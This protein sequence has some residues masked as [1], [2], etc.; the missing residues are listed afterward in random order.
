M[1]KFG[2]NLKISSDFFSF[3]K[4][5]ELLNLIEKISKRIRVLFRDS[6]SLPVIFAIC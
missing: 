1:H 2:E 6:E 3:S 4:K 5:L